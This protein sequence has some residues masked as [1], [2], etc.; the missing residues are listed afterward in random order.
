MTARMTKQPPTPD[1]WSAVRQMDG[2]V[3]LWQGHKYHVEVRQGHLHALD[4]TPTEPF[5]ERF[6]WWNVSESA[7]VAAERFTARL[8]ELGG[9]KPK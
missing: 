9:W 2:K 3:A 6:P 4:L 7:S 8:A 1:F 5:E